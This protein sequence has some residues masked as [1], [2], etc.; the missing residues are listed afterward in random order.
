MGIFADAR[1]IKAKAVVAGKVEVKCANKQCRKKFMARAADRARGWGKYC[2][3]SCK[4]IHQENRTGQY[5][6]YLAG[7]HSEQGSNRWTDEDGNRY[8]RRWTGWGRSLV[9]CEDA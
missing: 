6:H 9:S 3:K 4:A 8:S 1:L 2:S 7:V 5:A